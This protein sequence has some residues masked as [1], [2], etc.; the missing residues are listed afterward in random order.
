MGRSGLGAAPSHEK[1]ENEGQR[2]VSESKLHLRS[3][4]DPPSAARGRY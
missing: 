1:P 3:V 2:S 4:C